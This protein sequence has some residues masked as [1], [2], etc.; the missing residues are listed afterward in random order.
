M[1]V[2]FLVVVFFL[3]PQAAKS[4]TSRSPSSYSRSSMVC[5]GGGERLPSPPPLIQPSTVLKPAPM[6]RDNNSTASAR[7]SSWAE[8]SAS[9]T[10]PISALR[11]STL[12]PR[13]ISM[14]H[15]TVARYSCHDGHRRSSTNTSGSACWQPV[16][17]L[18]TAATRRARRRHPVS[19]HGGTSSGPQR[20]H[21]FVVDKTYA[22]GQFRQSSC[23]E[24]QVRRAPL[25]HRK[26]LRHQ[27]CGDTL[28][29]HLK[30]ATNA[31]H[32][33]PTYRG[34]LRN[35]RWRFIWQPD[36]GPTDLIQLCKLADSR[37]AGSREPNWVC[38]RCFAELEQ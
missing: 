14:R 10:R 20:P 2:A 35:G 33:G 26:D 27:S 11:L 3:W 31:G 22:L 8:M 29:T 17:R 38:G 30:A 9:M 32:V 19:I 37:S 15:C 4:K 12:H 13:P 21:R 5:Q 36:P 28:A 16:I 7:V 34:G 6:R 25:A 18:P 23:I 24:S 1:C